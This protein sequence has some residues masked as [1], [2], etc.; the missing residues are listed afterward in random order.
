MSRSRRKSPCGGHCGGHKVS[1]KD[2]KRLA[3]RAQRAAERA[4]LGRGDE[5]MPAVRETS[6]TWAMS[7]DGKGWWGR[8]CDPK[9]LRK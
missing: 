9:M 6:S 1:E 5:V 4:A 3:H 7:K 2:D 8:D